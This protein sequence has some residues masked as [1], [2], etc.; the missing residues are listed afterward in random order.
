MRTTV[1]FLFLP[2]TSGREI[3]SKRPLAV[4]DQIEL[5][6]ARGL[7]IP[8]R[9]RAARYLRFIG[10]YRLAVYSR[11]YQIG[12][13]SGHAFRLGV[14][15]DDILS[16]YV[17]DRQLRLLMM[18]AVERI[19]VAFRTVL[20]DHMSLK[21]GHQWYTESRH[22]QR[23]NKDF[24]HLQFIRIV[25]KET[26]YNGI[27]AGSPVF[28]KSYYKKYCE[29]VLPPSW[30]VAEV[31]PIGAWSRVY[32]VLTQAEDRKA[33]SNSFRVRYELFGS[34]IHA[35][36]YVRNVCAHHSLLWNAVF[37]VKPKLKGEFGF[38]E[39]GDKFYAQAA[40][41]QFLLKSISQQSMWGRRLKNHLEKCPL[42]YV[43]HMGFPEDWFNQ[44]L[45]LI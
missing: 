9:E 30:M 18:D 13:D 34:W 38:V 23:A 12:D 15:F 31:L 17:F 21:Y 24:D 5:L 7:H 28:C 37:T 4:G 39:R 32:S 27:K 40:V 43:E 14:S 33:V 25:Q 20:N 29:P 42:P 10:Y 45:W 36:S 26:G 19:E 22:F 3:F 6:E 44:E 11:P 2:M 8:D 16:L 1:G 41:I 35:V